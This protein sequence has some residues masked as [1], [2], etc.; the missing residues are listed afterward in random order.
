MTSAPLEPRATPSARTDAS[1]VAGD[2]AAAGPAQ[3]TGEPGTAQTPP[4][5]PEPDEVDP[6]EGPLAGRDPALLGDLAHPGA[7]AHH[8]PP[9]QG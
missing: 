6:A 2:A 4:G 5:Y 3:T 7:P 1:D 8:G 9:G